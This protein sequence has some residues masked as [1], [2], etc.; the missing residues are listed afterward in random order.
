MASCQ[1]FAH[2]VVTVVSLS[3]KKSP[4]IH[5]WLAISSR[6]Y[7]KAIDGNDRD[8]PPTSLTE[9]R[10]G[11]SLVISRVGSTCEWNSVDE[12]IIEQGDSILVKGKLR[13]HEHHLRL[14]GDVRIILVADN[15]EQRK[16]WLHELRLRI[17]SPR[18]LHQ[19][20]MDEVVNGPQEGIK[21]K[22]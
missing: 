4:R 17:A 20:I 22:S 14:S 7:W 9:F 1:H 19:R 13:G 18:L 8:K 6:V 15:E 10:S 16:Q 11:N 21:E 5:A 2:A 12:R 3:G